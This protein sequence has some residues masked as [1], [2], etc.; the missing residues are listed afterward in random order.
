[1]THT[2]VVFVGA[3]S[4]GKTTIG[5]QVATRL[6]WRFDD[7]VGYRLRL[8]VLRNDAK[9]LADI[10]QESFDQRVCEIEMQRDLERSGNTVVET[11]HLGNLA[12]VKARSPS[13]Y[14]T[15]KTQIIKHLQTYQP[16]HILVVPLVI[17]LETLIDRH[18]ETVENLSFFLRVGEL[19]MAEDLTVGMTVLEP[20]HTD[21]GSSIN[22]IVQKITDSIQDKL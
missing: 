6:G 3:H 5:Q 20:V 21:D 4:S 1:M 7:E 18:H 12:Y 8:E 16:V 19:A 17:T 13:M 22:T 2:I 15:L 9:Q 14:S 10:P 11:W